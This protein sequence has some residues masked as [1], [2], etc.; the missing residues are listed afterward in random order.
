[1]TVLDELRWTAGNDF[2]KIEYVTF[3]NVYLDLQET[4]KLLADMKYMGELQDVSSS[5]VFYGKDFKI[6]IF[7]DSYN[8]LYFGLISLKRPRKTKEFKP[9]SLKQCWY[10]EEFGTYI[11]FKTDEMLKKDEEERLE[12]ERKQKEYAEKQKQD[13]LVRFKKQR[14]DLEKVG[15]QDVPDFTIWHDDGNVYAIVPR[16]FTSQ[17]S[18]VYLQ[19]DLKDKLPEEL[20]CTVDYVGLCGY[21]DGK[22]W[23]YGMFTDKTLADHADYVRDHYKSMM[24]DGLLR[25]VIGISREKIYKVDGLPNDIKLAGK[26]LMTKILGYLK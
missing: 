3:N 18:G 21:D 1:M 14:A 26:E 9:L 8:G 23:L 15:A 5:L 25:P 13:M 16:D 6:Q 4:Y 12:K 24:K 20:R 10:S 2:D 7:E 11:P 19:S 17:S 22:W